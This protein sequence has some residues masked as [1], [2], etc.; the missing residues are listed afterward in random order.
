VAFTLRRHG[1]PS[2]AILIVVLALL[3]V[4]VIVCGLWVRF[5]LQE[6]SRQRL[7]EDAVQAEWLAEAGLRRA[8]A[9]HTAYRNFTG[10][11]WRVEGKEFDRSH[12]ATVN[13]TVEHSAA[14]PEIARL[15]A[16]VAYP[17]D[18]PTIRVSKTISFNATR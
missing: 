11:Q 8:A 14:A 5:V 2:G 6:V 1:R 17:S 16:H 18:V 3:A 9:R 4:L 13:L 15:T 7:Q 10:E 12:P